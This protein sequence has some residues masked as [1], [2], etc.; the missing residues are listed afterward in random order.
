MKLERQ[1]ELLLKA[2]RDN[3]PSAISAKS[4]KETGLLPTADNLVRGKLL[5]K[6]KF[7]GQPAYRLADPPRAAVISKKRSG[8]GPSN[9]REIERMEDLLRKSGG[10][11]PRRK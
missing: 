5:L 1:A 11:P 3:Y 9:E 10:M 2:A 8:S 6:S 7:K 4:I